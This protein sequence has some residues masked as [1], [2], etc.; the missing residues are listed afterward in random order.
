VRYNLLAYHLPASNGVCKVTLKFCEPH[1]D[2][3]GVRVF[4]VKL[5]Y[6]DGAT[7][8]PFS[9]PAHWVIEGV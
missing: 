3:T 7:V 5:R 1:Y 8:G 9:A 6:K 2:A 4:D